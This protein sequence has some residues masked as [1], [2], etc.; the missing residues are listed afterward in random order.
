MLTARRPRRGIWSKRTG[1][2]AVEF[3]LI[4]PILTTLLLGAFDI[5]PSLMVKFKTTSATQT[6]ADLA[7]QAATMQTADIQ[8]LFGA[9]SD[10]MTPFSGTPLVMRISNIATNGLGRAFV[11]WSCGQGALPPFAAATT[12]LT[13]PTG[14]PVSSLLQLFPGIS[15]LFITSGINTSYIMVESQYKY[16]APAGLFLPGSQLMTSVAYALPRVS[17]YVGPTTGAVGF[18]PIPPILITSSYATTVGGLTCN[19]G[20]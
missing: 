11:Y 9:G 20:Y 4:A 14:T 5:G 3:A 8:N 10:V 16:F 1:S 15:G 17:I 18:V 7:T 12:V 13:T 2:A 6:V 19:T